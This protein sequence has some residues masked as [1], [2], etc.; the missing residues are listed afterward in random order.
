MSLSEEVFQKINIAS[1]AL[2]ENGGG[3]H[4]FYPII[5]SNNGDTKIHIIG[6]SI[7]RG[8][9]QLVFNTPDS[10]LNSI[11]IDEFFNQDLQDAQLT[12]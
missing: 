8:S 12:S 9:I 1:E 10:I 6:L 3:N 7:Q 5:V 11:S 4:L 2:R